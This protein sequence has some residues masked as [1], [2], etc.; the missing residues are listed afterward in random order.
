MLPDN[1]RLEAHTTT[2]APSVAP[3]PVEHH[4]HREMWFVRS[5]EVVLMTNGET[6]IL[7]AGE[8]GLA[9]AGTDH[10]VANASK[11]EPCSYLVIAVG[12]PG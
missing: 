2:V 9:A 11:T 8:M 4:R 7:K 1:I 6:H 3:E 5:G 12:P 10:S